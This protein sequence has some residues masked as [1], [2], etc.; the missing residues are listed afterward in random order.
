MLTNK[1]DNELKKEDNMFCANCLKVTKEKEPLKNGRCIICGW[2]IGD[3]YHFF[4]GGYLSQ[5]SDC[6]FTIGDTKFT[7]AEQY[8]MYTKAVMFED[9][10]I[11]EQILETTDPSEQKRL[12]KLVHNFSQY[13]WDRE[14]YNIICT[15][16]LAK[17]TQ[18]LEHKEFLLNTG[19][20]II[21]EAS[22][23]DTV[24]GIG[25][26]IDDSRIWEPKQWKGTNLLG[27]CLVHVREL[28]KKYYKEN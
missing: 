18:D 1:T 14:K 9:Y 2:C 10:S 11:M 24:Y 28:I 3:K 12:G 15:G 7:S 6:S 20:K 17:F 19:N 5:W 4:Y 25:L 8:M 13:V 16:N 23:D 22:E 27:K 26:G 21:V